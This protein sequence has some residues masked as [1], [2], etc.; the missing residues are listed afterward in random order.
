ILAPFRYINSPPSKGVK[1]VL[2]DALNAWHHV[3]EG[4]LETIKSVVDLLHT[5]SLTF[6]DIEDNSILRRGMPTAHTIFGIGQTINSST[7]ILI[8]AVGVLTSRIF[9]LYL[10]PNI[11]GVSNMLLGQSIDLDT[12]YLTEC[13]SEEEYLT[14]VD[15]KTGR[16]FLMINQLMKAESEAKNP[17][18][19]DQLMMLFGRFFQIR[20]DYMNLAS[21]EVSFGLEE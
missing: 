8:K 5:S 17:A 2:I 6:D 21:D 4:S 19:F 16:L 9:K 13:P 10:T 12:T 11:E 1:D 18:D 14:M 15:N 20:V 3:P 7:Y